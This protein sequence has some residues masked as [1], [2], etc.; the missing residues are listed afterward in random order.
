MSSDEESLLAE[1]SEE[2]A[3]G[4]TTEYRA[5]IQAP[6]AP[7][8][9]DLYTEALDRLFAVQQSYLP[10]HDIVKIN[11]MLEDP[12]TGL[13]LIECSV[14]PF[15]DELEE[16]RFERLFE[17][18]DQFAGGEVAALRNMHA[19]DAER[20]CALTLYLLRLSSSLK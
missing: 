3:V 5:P 11:A 18:V 8:Y 10:P 17:V 1:S 14:R 2:E 6:A 9:R 7:T 13:T 16:R 20:L 4:E 15:E 19:K 12:L